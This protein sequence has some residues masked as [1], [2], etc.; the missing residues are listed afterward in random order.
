MKNNVVENF[1]DDLSNNFDEEQDSDRFKF[2][3]KP[4]VDIINAFFK[5][6]D[7]SSSTIL[8]IGAGTGRFSSIMAKKAKKVVAVD[9]SSNMLSKLKEKAESNSIYNIDIIKGN[10]LDIDF[11]K[12]FDY[13]VSFSAI[14]YIK[15]KEAL[16]RKI[17]TLLKPQGYIFITTAHRTFFRLFGR[18]GNYFRQ[19]I[20]MNAYSKKEI[21]SLLKK[22]N[23]TLIDIDDYV[24]K[25]ILL[26]GI[27]LKIHAQKN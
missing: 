6:K 17:S 2:I 15:D 3:R 21:K 7:L 4:E 1:Y 10:F 18:I 9:I 23:M 24:L 20:Y 27:L 11:T 5:D 19:K 22:Y 13:I 12:K 26:K 16:F 25:F 14:E 8:E